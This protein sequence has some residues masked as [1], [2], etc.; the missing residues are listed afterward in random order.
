MTTTLKEAA[1]KNDEAAAVTDQTVQ[2]T[3]KQ[4]QAKEAAVVS[5]R[6]LSETEARMTDLYKDFA[7]RVLDLRKTFKHQDRTD[8]TGRSREYRAAIAMVYAE[9]GIPTDREAGIQSNLRYHI[10]SALRR[11]LSKAKL[12]EYGLNEASVK[13]RKVTAEGERRSA[14]DEPRTPAAQKERDEQ[15]IRDLKSEVESLGLQVV[16]PRQAILL[17]PRFDI[18]EDTVCVALE[19]LAEAMVKIEAA[20]FDMAHLATA[21][22]QTTRIE[23][24]AQRI[25]K[26]LHSMSEKAPAK[27]GRTPAPA[28]KSEV[29]DV[30]SVVKEPAAA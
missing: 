17:D 30:D 14:S 4:L 6:S 23:A 20:G 12:V 13:D 2:L 18:S 29:I 7:E 10:S 1:P 9:A 3:S 5:L 28:G 11:R 24:S 8:W 15:S 19:A 27:A 25:L 21:V 16:D 26:T 22:E